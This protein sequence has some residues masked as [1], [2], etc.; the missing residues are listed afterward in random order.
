MPFLYHSIRSPWLQRESLLRIRCL[1]RIGIL[2]LLSLV[3]GHLRAAE[4]WTTD[5]DFHNPA[6]FTGGADAIE[7]HDGGYLAIGY[8]RFQEGREDAWAARFDRDGK[9]RWVRRIR[10]PRQD[11][12]R[13]VIQTRDRGYVIVGYGLDWTRP[14]DVERAKKSV[15][16]AR[17]IKLG[18]YGQVM[19]QRS[20]GGK[21]RTEAYFAHALADGGVLVVGQQWT[22]GKGAGRNLW[23]L[24]LNFA[25]SKVGE[26]K[27]W[28]GKETVNDSLVTADGNLAVL[29][30]RRILELTLDGKDLGEHVLEPSQQPL[31][32]DR[33]RGRP[34]YIRNI[35]ETP[36]GG[37]LAIGKLSVERDEAVTI[38]IRLDA[39]GQRVWEKTYDRPG[40]AFPSGV[41]AL[42]R[43]RFAAAVHRTNFPHPASLW[44]FGIDS[45][46]ERLWEQE[47]FRDIAYGHGRFRVVNG[48]SLLFAGTVLTQRRDYGATTML[49]MLK[50]DNSGRL[51]P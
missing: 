11:R 27:R 16:K 32:R 14:G 33:T 2:L 40:V 25:G 44:L 42:S 8:K 5:F 18:S 51:V 4:T 6:A 43:D 49:W 34:I 46:G 20:L 22:Y 21:L 48:R 23:L 41:V 28:V 29:V 47:Y 15:T 39:L 19:W 13:S 38:L 31:R 36:D 17:V 10:H 1:A 24:R 12:P 45:D 26:W 3:P 35:A 50:A 30:G 7:V 37:Y 9:P